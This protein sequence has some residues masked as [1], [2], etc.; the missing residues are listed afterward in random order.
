M[1]AHFLQTWRSLSTSQTWSSSTSQ[2]SKEVAAHRAHRPLG[3]RPQL[4]SSLGEENSEVWDI[5]LRY[6][7]SILF[8][9]TTHGNS[10][11]S[12]TRN[13]TIL[14]ATRIAFL[15]V[16]RETVNSGRNLLLWSPP[17]SSQFW[18]PNTT[19][20]VTTRNKKR[21]KGRKGIVYKLE[22]TPMFG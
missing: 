8:L 2:C 4:P 12:Q 22:F 6:L 21:K 14:V 9:V 1:G 16:R 17:R 7:E 5:L 18:S 10:G 3:L 15:A 11:R 13:M 20:L 19:N